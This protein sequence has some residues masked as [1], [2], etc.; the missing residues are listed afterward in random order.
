MAR[1]NTVSATFKVS[2]GTNAEAVSVKVDNASFDSGE[3]LVINGV[4]PATT[5]VTHDINDFF[6]ASAY[7]NGLFFQ[8]RDSTHACTLLVKDDTGTPATI[9]NMDI[10]AG[11]GVLIRTT[12][13]IHQITITCLNAGETTEYTLALA[14]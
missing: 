2:A 1:Q 5:G 14:E 7:A 8:N 6:G 10:P 4:A 9:F 13:N 11:A 12:T 3:S